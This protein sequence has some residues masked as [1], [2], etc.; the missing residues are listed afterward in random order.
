MIK[1]TKWVECDDCGVVPTDACCETQDMTDDCELRI[2]LA[3]QGWKYHRGEDV[4]PAC[5]E[6]RDTPR[7]IPADYRARRGEG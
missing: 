2:W 4:C 5:H 1:I 6:K 7:F 3:G